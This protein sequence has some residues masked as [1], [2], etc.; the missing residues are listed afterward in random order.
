MASVPASLAILAVDGTGFKRW[1]DA[2]AGLSNRGDL[3]VALGVTA[4]GAVVP[5]G[6]W[7]G[8]TWEQVG[9]AIRPWTEGVKPLAE[10]LV[11]DGETDLVK[12]LSYLAERHQRCYW[13]LIH[14]LDAMLWR[15]DALGGTPPAPAELAG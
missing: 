15:Q 2:A 14:D 10:C 1:P 6:A 9:E 4:H 3:L 12:A 5:V 13:H 11:S 8:W 7:T